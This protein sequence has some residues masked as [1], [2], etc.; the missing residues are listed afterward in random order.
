VTTSINP[1]T[2]GRSI[3]RENIDAVES[4]GIELDGRLTFGDWRV[5][6]SYSLADARVHASGTAAPLDGLRPAQTARQQ[7]STTLA[8]SPPHR[9]SASLTL[10][11]IGPQYEDDQNSQR[12]KDALTLDAT[13]LLPI[14][15]GFSV[16]ARAEN[17]ANAVIQTTLSGPTIERA[18]P[19]TLWRGVRY[20]G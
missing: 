6:A 18:Q 17:L 16:E 8:W 7:A 10:R 20:G 12:L 11:Y 3:L 2:G 15:H 1:V 9:L 4:K 19:R 13:A 5:S 14:G